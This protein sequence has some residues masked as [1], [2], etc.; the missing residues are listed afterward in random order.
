MYSE[1]N[2][3]EWKRWIRLQIARFRR[4][5]GL[6]QEQ[7]SERIG[8]GQQYIAQIE[9][10][11]SKTFPSIST[12]VEI[13]NALQIPFFWFFYIEGQPLPFEEE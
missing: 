8:K 10:E 9:G 2:D 13:A 5:R 7:L 12:L 3:K 1:M 4:E 6:T 11:N